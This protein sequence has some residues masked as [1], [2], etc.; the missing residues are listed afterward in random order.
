[1]VEG[2]RL[3]SVCASNRT[4]S[5]NLILSA[6]IR[7]DILKKIMKQTQDMSRESIKIVKVLLVVAIGLGFLGTI[8]YL[9]VPVQPLT[10]ALLA[11]VPGALSLLSALAMIWSRGKDNG[12]GGSSA[13]GPL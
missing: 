11:W 7:G 6:K 5:S 3:E 2:A 9:A 8:L 10:A 1:M 13:P 12:D 4:V